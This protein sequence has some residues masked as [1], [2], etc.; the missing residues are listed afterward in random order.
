M[1]NGFGLYSAKQADVLQ[2]ETDEF[3]FGME[4][5]SFLS[6]ARDDS[7]LNRF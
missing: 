1:K 3:L 7:K 6:P 5:S 2:F 4:L